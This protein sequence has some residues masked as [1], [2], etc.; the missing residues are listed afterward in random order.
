MRFVDVLGIKSQ[1]AVTNDSFLQI[2]PGNG[3][4]ESV[5]AG[6]RASI[7]SGLTV[8][9]KGEVV[10]APSTAG[11]GMSALILVGATYCNL[12]VLC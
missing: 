5:K 4:E 7:A 12:T 2:T 10:P 9:Q 3:I 6:F 8:F 1:V 11:V